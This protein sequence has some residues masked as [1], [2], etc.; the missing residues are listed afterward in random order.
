M[1]KTINI[2]ALALLAAMVCSCFPGGKKENP[3]DGGRTGD[4][5]SVSITTLNGR[6][7]KDAV[8][9]PAEAYVTLTSGDESA[10]YTATY[11]LGNKTGRMSQLY[12]DP[13]KKRPFNDAVSLTE[14]GSYRLVGEV[15]REDGTED[16]VPFE[17]EVWM[18]GEETTVSSATITS[19]K[20]TVPFSKEK[21]QMYLGENGV[22]TFSCSPSD[23]LTFGC[24]SS[25]TSAILID[26][27]NITRSGMT[28]T[29][30]FSVTAAGEAE[31]TLS[32]TNGPE[33]AE[34]KQIFECLS[35]ES[36]DYFFDFEI[37]VPTEAVIGDDIPVSVALTA[38]VESAT[39][40]IAC[41]LDGEP[42]AASSGVL[43]EVLA[44]KRTAIIP[45]S[46]VTAG[47]HEV[48]VTVS[49]SDGRRSV[50]KKAGFRAAGVPVTAVTAYG[51]FNGSGVL[52]TLGP[53]TDVE[54][55]DEVLI[56]IAVEP[57][58]AT[59]RDM[60]ASVTGAGVLSVEKTGEREFSLKVNGIGEAVLKAV[61]RGII[62]YS[63][64]YRF[65][66][67]RTVRYGAGL[68]DGRIGVWFDDASLSG[69]VV[70]TRWSMTYHGECTYTETISDKD[71]TTE[72]QTQ[73]FTKK[74]TPSTISGEGL[75]TLSQT[76]SPKYT[77][78]FEKEW[79][80]IAS[81]FEPGSTWKGTEKLPS[82]DSL[83]V[84]ASKNF[85]Y[86]FIIDQ[87]EVKT[88]F[89]TGVKTYRKFEFIGGNP[90]RSGLIIVN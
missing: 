81:M 87:L 26:R 55:G 46:R 65:L 70:S 66:S 85:P 4:D 28:W 44:E 34:A 49:R 80:A 10:A 15:S 53:V 31:V 68:G 52:H 69:T 62:D 71:Y 45:G 73:S 84:S 60:T 63:Y 7:T 23:F 90:G 8:I 36:R 2:Q 11:S 13:Q 35:D 51:R 82:G 37:S 20:V 83:Y 6:R 12:V 29:V 24:K 21:R 1:K 76:T 27:E 72:P 58:D 38:G 30:P 64:E 39:Y 89:D 22:M 86:E 19:G 59:V 18:L 32:V 5:L 74:T 88:T 41:L 9:I 16:P 40:D 57:A 61:V 14:F 47:D 67:T 33:T 56:S 25:N 43:G 54:A 75:A 3:D 50:T 77:F 79:K 48:T 17:A 42:A 78:E